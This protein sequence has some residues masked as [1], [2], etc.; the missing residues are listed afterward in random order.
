MQLLMVLTERK[1]R[2]LRALAGTAVVVLLMWQADEVPNPNEVAPKVQWEILRTAGGGAAMIWAITLV[3]PGWWTSKGE[4]RPRDPGWTFKDSPAATATVAATTLIA[5]FATSGVLKPLFDNAELA[6]VS[7]GL[8]A[9][10]SA[11]ATAAVSLAPFALRAA[12]SSLN[13][14]TRKGLF[15]AAS[16]VTLGASFLVLTIAIQ[17]KVL[18]TAKD[19]KI[20][21]WDALTICATPV[22]CL[23]VYYVV[24]SVRDTLEDVLAPKVDPSLN[25]HA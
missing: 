7:L 20:T 18:P 16:A 19:E 15:I 11:V 8:I 5:L 24:L 2:Q 22:S 1:G 6:D 21:S 9:I 17:L 25:W 14:V 4:P 10:A 3:P 12:G 23:L 13:N